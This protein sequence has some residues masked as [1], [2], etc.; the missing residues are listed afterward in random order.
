MS[1]FLT[2]QR[3]GFRRWTAED[4]PLAQSL[5]TDAEVMGHMGGP[6]SNDAAAERLALEIRNQRMFGFQYWLIFSLESGAHAGCSGLRR[7]HDQPNV[8]EVG[9]HL[10]RPFW[11]G[12]V[13]EEAA[14]AVI[15]Y[16]WQNTDAQALVA[17][18]GP[19]N[20]HSKAL[21]GRLGF[22][23]THHEP[24]GPHSAQHPYYRLERQST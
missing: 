8:L 6:M 16:A 3:L 10:A 21:V 14:R 20:V 9:V 24:W 5:W 19:D 7:F 18:H 22:A 4:L 13:G 11:S 1:Y 15:A 2:T 17:G 23:Y 12:R